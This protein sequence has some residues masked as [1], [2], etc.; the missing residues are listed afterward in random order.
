MSSGLGFA[1]VVFER[2]ADTRGTYHM[3]QQVVPIPQEAMENAKHAFVRHGRSLGLDMREVKGDQV[4]DPG[5]DHYFA[6]EIWSSRK[7]E[8][9]RPL[10]LMH[11]SAPGSR[12]AVQFGREVLAQV[13]GSP[14]RAHWKA[15]QVSKEEEAA[16]TD[17]FKDAFAPFD[18]TMQS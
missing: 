6:V 10:R 17:A 4:E 14:E 9:G 12:V 18:F 15:C 3:H 1:T 5:E 16:A 8:T 2:F 13:L 7:G 11:R